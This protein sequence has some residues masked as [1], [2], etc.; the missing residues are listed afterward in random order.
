MLR[1]EEHK[2]LQ[3]GNQMLILFLLVYGVIKQHQVDVPGKKQ[4]AHRLEG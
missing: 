1:R 3:K 4:N 2:S